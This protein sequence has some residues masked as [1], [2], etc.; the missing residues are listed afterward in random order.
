MHVL[1]RKLS[2][3][4]V[5]EIFVRANSLGMKLRGSDLAGLGANHVPMARCITLETAVEIPIRFEVLAAL[6]NPTAPQFTFLV[7][8][9]GFISCCNKTDGVVFTGPNCRF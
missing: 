9:A 2:Y 7:A 6:E 1:D 3:V 8:S 5:A 4:E